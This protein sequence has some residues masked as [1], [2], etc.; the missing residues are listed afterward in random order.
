M[1]RHTISPGAARA[2]VDVVANVTG[3]PA[4]AILGR[5]RQPQIAR[6]RHMTY[7]AMYARG[8]SFETIGRLMQRDHSTVLHGVRRARQSLEAMAL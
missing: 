6:A 3:V 5:C 2:I 4:C 7:L 1:R 8:A